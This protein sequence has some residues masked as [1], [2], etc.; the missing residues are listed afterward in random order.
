VQF[1]SIRFKASVLYSVI[2]AVILTVFSSV[3]YFGARNILYHDLDEDLK[4]KAEEIAGIL[5]AYEQIQHSEGYPLARILQMLS[6]KGISKNQSVVID[7]LWKSE[8]KTLNL[9]NDYISVANTQGHALLVS[10]NFTQ[11]IN[12]LFRKQFPSFSREVSYKSLLND[13]FKL[14]A[15]ALP[16][17]YHRSQ[18]VIEVGTPLEPVLKILNKILVFII[19]SVIVVL[20]LTSFIGSI[21]ARDALKPVLAV[22]NLADNITHKDLTARI[23]EQQVD[24]EMKHLVHSFNG[25][26]YRLEQSFNHISEFSS[27]V[28]HELK[29]PLAII[30]GEIELV[31]EGD[32]NPEEYK[33]VLEKCLEETDRTIRVIKDIL[34]LAR[35]DYKPDVFKFEKF[36][37]IQFLEEIYEH[38]QV[39]AS[40]KNIEVKLDAPKKNIFV[41]GDRVHLRRLFLNLIT[42]AVKFTPRKGEIGISIRVKDS[43]AY[44]DISDTGEGVSSADLSKIFNKFFRVRKDEQTA[45]PGTGLGL[46]IAL[47]IAKAHKGDIKVKSRLHEGTTFTVILPLA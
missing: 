15:I 37:L 1:N 47:S 38:S 14:R 6:N 34:L 29:T 27:H 11:K 18:L 25:M 26:I 33:N 17:S 32:E 5:S 7:D 44:V 8:I 20:V 43:K 4:I 3:I 45:E 12:S 42:N 16:V 2:L 40:S 10:N 41:N 19:A 9:K 31:L 35:F 22:A 23:G 39:F 30:K 36:K 13:K 21:F 46:S 28:A 24:A